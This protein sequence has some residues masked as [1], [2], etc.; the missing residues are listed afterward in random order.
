MDRM[1]LVLTL[2]YGCR[3]W[4]KVVNHRND[5]INKQLLTLK[6]EEQQ[7]IIG[8]KPTKLEIANIYGIL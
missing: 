6:S 1:I 7:R 4:N 2:N 8:N 3:I 5:C